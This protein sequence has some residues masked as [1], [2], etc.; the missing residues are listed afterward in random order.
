MSNS[1]LTT[2]K[3]SS[4]KLAQDSARPADPDPRLCAQ[5]SHHLLSKLEGNVPFLRASARDAPTNPRRARFPISC[6]HDDGAGS[7]LLFTFMNHNRVRFEV[8]LTHLCC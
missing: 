6:E 5:R 1:R 2:F 7:D 4:E 8:D 3:L